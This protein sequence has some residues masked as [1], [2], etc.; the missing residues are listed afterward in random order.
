[1]RT[2][3]EPHSR[4]LVL[5]F[6]LVLL[7]SLLALALPPFSGAAVASGSVFPRALPRDRD[8]IPLESISQPTRTPTSATLPTD[9]A[10]SVPTDL[11]TAPPVTPTL[12]ASSTYTAVPATATPTP[13]ASL[14]ATV[15]P[16]ATATPSETLLPNTTPTATPTA[17]STTTTDATIT[18]T[19]TLTV[20]PSATRTETLSPSETI[21]ATVEP[22]LLPTLTGTPTDEIGWIT[23]H[24]AAEGITDGAGVTITCGT[25]ASVTLESDLTFEIAAVP[26]VYTCIAHKPRF[27][28]ARRDG[29]LVEPGQ[30]VQLPRVKLTAGD[31]NGDGAVEVGDASLV[32]A[33]FGSVAPIESDLNGDGV[34]NVLDL[35]LVSGNFGIKGIQPW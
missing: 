28:D 3:K 19:F 18:P 5:V 13:T 11:S 7:V 6:C 10:T 17:S 12:T 31:V 8:S 2:L 16:T 1:M 34:V 9:D 33:N 20:E 23:G 4:V 32:A 27:L 15:L 35:I 22:T 25:A 24:V 14:P 29:I 21:T 26:G 30:R